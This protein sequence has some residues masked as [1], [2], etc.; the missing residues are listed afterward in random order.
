M[1]W[2]MGCSCDVGRI[3]AQSSS[4]INAR[5]VLV[6]SLLLWSVVGS[7]RAVILYIHS[8]NLVEVLHTVRSSLKEILLPYRDYLPAALPVKDIF[9]RIAFYIHLL[10]LRRERCIC[11]PPEAMSKSAKVLE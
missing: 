7:I 4:A 1:R 5:C 2:R 9:F 11:Y 6:Q 3:G 10:S 8:K